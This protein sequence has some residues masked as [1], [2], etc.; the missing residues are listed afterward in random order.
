[1]KYQALRPQIF[2]VGGWWCRG[3]VVNGGVG[4]GGVSGHGVGGGVGGG[5]RWC[6]VGVVGG[7]VG[8]VWWW[9]V[10][11][12]VVDGVIRLSFH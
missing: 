11:W 5:G 9:V 3:G 10:G 6:G 4:G 7:G 12:S 1:M 8:V 2:S